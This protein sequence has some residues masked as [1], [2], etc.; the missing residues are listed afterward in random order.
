VFNGL[1]YVTFDAVFINNLALTEE[2]EEEEQ[3]DRF[4]GSAA[5]RDHE[6]ID[7]EGV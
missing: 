6:M 4:L 2:E 7:S 5:K 3:S 1:I